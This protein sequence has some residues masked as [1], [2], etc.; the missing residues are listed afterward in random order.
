M[1]VHYLGKDNSLIQDII[2]EL[3]SSDLQA[4][5]ARFRANLRKLGS[6]AAYE[7]SKTLSYRDE[8]IETPLGTAPGKCIDDNLVLATI[9]RAGLPMHSGMV[10][11]F[12]YAQNAFIAAYRSHHKDGTFEISSEYTTCPRL[13]GKTLVLCDPMLATGSSMDAALQS[14]SALGDPKVT[15]IVII[16]AS[17][18]GLRYIQGE[19]PDAHL[20]V[21]AEDQE[22]TAKSYIVPGLGDAGDLA[23]GSKE[24]D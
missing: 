23:Y 20:W 5:P 16:I 9:L 3:R 11:M 12:P 6:I 18:P 17:S 14:L 7:I 1:K 8:E 10:D 4:D 13:E 15:H 2:R 19:Y 21:F 24:Q 22:L